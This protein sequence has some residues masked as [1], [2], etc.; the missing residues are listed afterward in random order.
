MLVERNVQVLNVETVGE[1]YDIAA[2]YLKKTG[3]IA[4]SALINDPLLEVISRLFDGGTRNRLLLA[5]KAITKFE[6]LHAPRRA[7]S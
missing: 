2:H 3:Q 7:A 4:D 6:R 5:N 1:A